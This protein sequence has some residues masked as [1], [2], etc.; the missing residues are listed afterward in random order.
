MSNKQTVLTAL[1]CAGSLA[2]MLAVASPAFASPVATDAN[3][4]AD[5][6]LFA[7][8]QAD[9]NPIMDALRCGCATCAM[10]DTQPIL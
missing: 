10:S 8:T 2:A 5:E 9:S 7:L 4:G 3:A 6:G 1:G